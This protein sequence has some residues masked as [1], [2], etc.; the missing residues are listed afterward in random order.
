MSIAPIV[1]SVA[2]KLPPERAF[3]V[4]AGRMGEWWA[5]SH[6]IAPKPF[7]EIV[8]EPRAEGRWFERDAD[9]A[10]C[11]WGKVLVWDPPRL[12]VLGWQLTPEFK[13]DPDFLTEV[14]ILFVAEGS[15]TRVTLTHKQLERFGSQAKTILD[16][17]DQGWGM[18]LGLF[19]GLADE[20]PSMA[21]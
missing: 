14:E 1:Q 6:H 17:I 12:L 21:G 7:A 20:A 8:V 18:L 16:G 5:A 3:Q 9:G 15:G 13:Y 19:R 4:F 2:V 10:E 11:E